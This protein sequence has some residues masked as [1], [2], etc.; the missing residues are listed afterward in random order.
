MNQALI[1]H[2]KQ[3]QLNRKDVA[4]WLFLVLMTLPHLEPLYL[5]TFP[6]I[7][8]IFTL[9]KAAT[10]LIMCF[11]FL[12]TRRKISYVILLTVAWRG[13]LV[14]STVLH[15]GQ[16]YGSI[17][18]SLSI[19]SVMLLYELTYTQKNTT[20]LSAQLFCFEIVIYINFITEL[21]F[22]NGMYLNETFP[23]GPNW[24][25]GYYNSYTVYCIPALMFA[26]LYK[27][28]TD[29][30]FRTYFLTVI[31][32]A[33]DI[34]VFAGGFTMAL[35]S[36]GIVYIFFKG[37]TRIFNYINYWMLHII[38]LV[39]I[40]VLKLQN[41][42][43]VLLNDILGKWSSLLSRMNIW[44]QTFRFIF[45]SPW[46]GY[47]SQEK[48]RRLME[49]HSNWMIHSHNMFLEMLYQVG[50]IGLIL[51]AAVV[52]VAGRNLMKHRDTNESKI[53][54]TAFLGWCICTLV[55]PFTSSFLMG[56]F[57]IAYHSNRELAGNRQPCRKR[58]RRRTGKDR[59]FKG[60][61]A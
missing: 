4:Y 21:I 33:S 42:F 5:D 53:I 46:I 7:G 10:L 57:V 9:M 19:L 3:F 12:L 17:A 55:E 20:F 48:T 24:F 56:M 14:L 47:G 40:I 16:V 6:S 37:R 23:Y 32:I 13:V 39:F 30:K 34:V 43:F 26:W 36:M 18:S 61:N 28:K 49:F 27:E 52:I 50:I 44:D 38:F 51:F 60:Q 25:L 1:K 15:D 31:I 35:A 22:P 54:A 58:I 29:K 59:S 41:L 11:C 2:P 45:K 8:M